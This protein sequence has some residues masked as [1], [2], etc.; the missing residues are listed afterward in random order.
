M[1]KTRGASHWTDDSPPQQER[2]GDRVVTHQTMVEMT[3]DAFGRQDNQE[4]VEE[5]RF[6]NRRSAI[7][8][9]GWQP[10]GR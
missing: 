1:Q 7:A 9:S 2:S 4:Q 5:R 10:S 6:E 3:I 8:Q